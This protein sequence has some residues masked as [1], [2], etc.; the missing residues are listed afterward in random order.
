M[1]LFIK[2]IYLEYHLVV[3]CSIENEDKSNMVASL[4]QFRRQFPAVASLSGIQNY[5]KR[6][7]VVSGAKMVGDVVW[8]PAATVDMEKWVKYQITFF[9]IF[10]MFS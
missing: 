2:H 7:L 6:Q 9:S 3:I 5:L 10:E 8:K 1:K 4:D